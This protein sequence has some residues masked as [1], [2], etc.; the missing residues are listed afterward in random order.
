[1]ECADKYCTMIAQG[2]TEDENDSQANSI[3]E[4]PT[5]THMNICYLHQAEVSEH[6]ERVPPQHRAQL[7]PGQCGEAALL[8]EEVQPRRK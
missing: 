5:Q 1:M 8:S 3:P 2:T 6:L 7:Y 4:V